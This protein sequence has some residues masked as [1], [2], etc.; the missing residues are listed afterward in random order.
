[1]TQKAKSATSVIEL[2]TIVDGNEPETMYRGQGDGS[3]ALIPSLG[4]FT[5]YVEGGYEEIAQ[6][7]Q[8]LLEK[9]AQYSV[10]FR[11]LRSAPLIEQLV[12]CQHFGLPTRLLDWTTNPLKAL[13]FA[14][15]DPKLDA[16]DGS[17]H[18]TLPR[19]WWEGTGY[20]K[21]IDRLS[22]FFP[23]L[24][25][26]RVVAQDACFIAFPLPKTG[27]HIPEMSLRNYPNAMRFLYQIRVPRKS[28]R[29]LRQELAA[30]GISHRTV[31][32]GLD[33]VAKWVKSTLSNFAT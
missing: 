16:V 6:L 12:H 10:P 1:M 14:V 15:E 18:V 7:E 4:R 22:A 28:K 21:E 3:W 5:Q 31:Y 13:F 19:S 27:M 26:D 29:D 24:L 17:V 8:H 20:I 33:G 23:E 9:Y 32:P 25:H 2:L 11:D 30:L